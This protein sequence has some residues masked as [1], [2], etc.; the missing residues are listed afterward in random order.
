MAKTVVKI[1]VNSVVKYLCGTRVDISEI[2]SLVGNITIHFKRINANR[3]GILKI[4]LTTLSRTMSCTVLS[5]RKSFKWPKMG[6]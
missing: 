5:H 3:T 6:A 2:K 1:N 4:I